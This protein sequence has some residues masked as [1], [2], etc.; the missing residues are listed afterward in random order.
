MHDRRPCSGIQN[1]ASLEVWDVMEFWHAEAWIQ[2]SN[3][4]ELEVR[5]LR[6]VH[7]L[8]CPVSIRAFWWTF[9]MPFAG[10]FGFVP[11]VLVGFV[12]VYEFCY[13]L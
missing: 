8:G 5:E 7:V 2:R 11:K 12:S 10:L 13:K 9:S 3:H 4:V 6:S 1:V